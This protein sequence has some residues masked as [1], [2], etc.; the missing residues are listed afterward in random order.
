MKACVLMDVRGKVLK[1]TYIPTIKGVGLNCTWKGNSMGLYG[2]V[3]MVTGLV[4]G[5]LL[6]C[7][8]QVLQQGILQR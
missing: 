5:R 8:E 3:S 6:G 7:I 2:I 4:K 1:H